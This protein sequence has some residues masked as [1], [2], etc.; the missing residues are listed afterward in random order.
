M[1]QPHDFK[2]YPELTDKQMEELYFESP[3]K[4]ITENFTATCV[5]VQDG[6]TITVN[7]NER[8][9]NFPVRFLDIAAAELGTEKGKA[10]QQWLERKLLGRE[11][12]IIID[13]KNRVDKWGRLMGRIYLMGLNIGQESINAGHSTDWDKV[14]EGLIIDSIQLPKEFA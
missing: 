4:Q 9:F 12:D 1:S 11:I 14:N 10:A 5:K 3:H 8:D 7:W 2:A 13:Q 6:D